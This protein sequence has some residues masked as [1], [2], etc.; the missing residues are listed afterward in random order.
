[1]NGILRPDLVAQILDY[2]LT[3]YKAE[4]IGRLE[5]YQNG[6]TYMFLIGVPSYMVP[7][8]NFYEATNDEDFLTYIF[9]ELRTRNFMKIDKYKVIRTNIDAREE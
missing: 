1:M 9:E 3:L 2:I 5:V 4:Y 8:T 7:T 6:T